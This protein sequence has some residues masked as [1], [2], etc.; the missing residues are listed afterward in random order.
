MEINL[1]LF[2]QVINFCIA[3]ALLRILYFKPA[4]EYIAHRKKEYDHLVNTLSCWQTKI[5]TKEH[6]KSRMWSDFKT[7]SKIHGPSVEK[8]EVPFKYSHPLPPHIDQKHVKELI[9]ETKELIIEG[10]SRVDI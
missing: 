3:W 6:E 10:V 5:T 1:T 2:V 4:V 7:F 9:E 8:T